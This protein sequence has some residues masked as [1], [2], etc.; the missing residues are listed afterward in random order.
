MR[1]EKKRINLIMI[2]LI[3]TRKVCDAPVRRNMC[4]CTDVKWKEI[5][6]V[7]RESGIKQASKDEK[8]TR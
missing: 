7:V 4:V 1:K 6:E 2:E 3:F 5:E 8:P